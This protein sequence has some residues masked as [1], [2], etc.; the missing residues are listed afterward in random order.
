V[1]FWVVAGCQKKAAESV[2]TELPSIPVAHPAQQD[3]VDFVDYTGRTDAVHSESIRPQVTGMLDKTLFKEGGVVKTGELLFEIN[4]VIFQ[5]QVEGAQAT[6]EGNKAALDQAKEQLKIDQ[7]LVGNGAVSKLTVEKDVAAVDEAK[8]RIDAAKAQLDINKTYLGYTRV[9][10]PIDGVVSR[11]NYTPGNIVNQNSTLLTTVV[12]MDPMYGYFDMDERTYH[13][14]IQL[15]NEKKIKLPQNNSTTP[16]DLRKI[17]MAPPPKSTESPGKPGKSTVIA[18]S[19]VYMATEG[20]TEILKAHEGLID[21]INNQ[22]NPS[23]GTISVRGVFANPRPEGGTWPLVPGMFVRFRLPLGEPHPALLVIDRAIGS[24]QGLKFVY[25]AV[26]EKNKDTGAME[27]RA[28][29]RRVATGALQENGLRVVT[30]MNPNQDYE[31]VTDPTTKKTIKSGL[32]PDELVI[33]GGLPQIRPKT[34]I[35]P[36]EDPMPTLAS[37]EPAIANRQRPSGQVPGKN[38]K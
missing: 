9:L 29:Y 26:T 20:Q 31:E 14:Y 16:E 37:N 11:Y 34:I 6:L 24:D 12:S 32:K 36:Q 4:P 38:K 25:V 3:V 19:K 28:E 33:V 21:F 2:A 23:T 10:S 17:E 15:I 35:K 18:D 5:A 27:T 22:V 7:M 8:A 30:S 1:L 13:K